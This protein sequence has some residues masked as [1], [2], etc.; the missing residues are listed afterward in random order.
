M[1][2]GIVACA[3]GRQEYLYRHLQKIQGLDKV[4]STRMTIG[5]TKGD[6]NKQPSY[7]E[8]IGEDDIIFDLIEELNFSDTSQTCDVDKIIPD[9]NNNGLQDDNMGQQLEVSDS[10]S[11]NEE[12]QAEHM[13]S[14]FNW[15]ENNIEAV[16][17]MTVSDDELIEDTTIGRPGTYVQ[18][19]IISTRKRTHCASG[20][21]TG[22]TY[23]QFLPGEEIKKT[24]HLI[25]WSFAY[26]QARKGH[27]IQF[28]IDHHRFKR[29]IHTTETII[30]PI[31]SPEHRLKIYNLITFNIHH[32][33]YNP[34]NLE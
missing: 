24:H 13:E 28:A 3:K 7:Y 1:N 14:D 11:P 6:T 15:Q 27:W 31:L 4:K 16:S 18:K 26:R 17:V 33:H 5:S 32:T 10:Q 22:S 25:A 8:D 30:T 2:I 29:R 34:K 9:E 20:E 12:Q 23:V 19:I 21:E